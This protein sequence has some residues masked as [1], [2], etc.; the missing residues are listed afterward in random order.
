MGAL[1]AREANARIGRSSH[2]FDQVRRPFSIA[3]RVASTR[4]EVPVLS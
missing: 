1:K 2:A 4:V 3:K